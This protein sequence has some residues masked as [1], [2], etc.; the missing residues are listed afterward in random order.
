MDDEIKKLLKQNIENTQEILH[1]V[2]KLNRHILWQRIFR[3]IKWTVVIGLIIFGFFQI[4][5]Y[6]DL[7]YSSFQKLGEM[8]DQLQSIP[9]ALQGFLP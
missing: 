9:G 3:I 2:K 6:L 4:Q 1:T 7:I 5:P 8:S